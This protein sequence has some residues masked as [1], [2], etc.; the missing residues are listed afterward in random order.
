M[1]AFEMQREFSVNVCKGFQLYCKD[2]HIAVIHV[3]NK[4]GKPHKQTLY[5]VIKGSRKYILIIV[6]CELALAAGLKSP[7]QLEQHYLNSL[8]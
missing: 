3:L 7:S 1:T 4:P 6:M 8:K 2:H 5:N